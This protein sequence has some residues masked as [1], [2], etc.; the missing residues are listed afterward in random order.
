MIY[1]MLSILCSTF[2]LLVFKYISNHHAQAFP[3][4]VINYTVCVVCGIITAQ[5][6]PS[7]INLKSTNWI[8]LSICM[9]TLFITVFYLMSLSVRYVGITK[10]SV[11]NK[12][13]LIIPVISAY[14]LYS[15]SF[16]EWKIAGIVLALIA[17]YL[18]VNRKQDADSEHAL[19]LYLVLP[20][21]VFA[22]S[23]L[24]DTLAK[25]A[26]SSIVPEEQ[27]RFFLIALFST[28]A[29]I[30]WIILIVHILQKRTVVKWKT[31][32]AGIFLGVP[33]YG[34]MYFLIMGLNKSGLQSSVFFPINN[35]A[36]VVLSFLSAVF[37]FKEH[38]THKN[39]LGIGLALVAIVLIMQ[40]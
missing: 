37:I 7:I 11:A 34:S 23:G 31:I 16:N 24:I 39:M 27:Y 32:L 4:I 17:I 36:I 40:A 18:V 6:L 8:L 30:G 35:I 13:S 20:L 29:V 38:Y 15:D 1:L 19:I 5:E 2:I 25:Y 21:L 10:T 12:L 14:F 33:N 28:A 26:E 3:V 22:G 9:G